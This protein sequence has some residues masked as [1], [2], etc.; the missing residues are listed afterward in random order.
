MPAGNLNA[1]GQT[2]IDPRAQLLLGRAQRQEPIETGMSLIGRLAALGVGQSQQRGF[3]EQIAASRL[4]YSQALQQAGTDPTSRLSVLSQAAASPDPVM[5]SDALS[6]IANLT[7]QE[8]KLVSTPGGG[9]AAV[10]LQ[11]NQ[12]SGVQPVVA[13]RAEAPKMFEVQDGEQTRTFMFDPE[14]GSMVDVATAPRET[15]QRILPPDVYEQQIGLR[16]AAGRAQGE[17]TGAALAGMTD[18]AAARA[19]GADVVAQEK[20]AREQA[21]IKAR[22]TET[23]T[24]FREAVAEWKSDPT[25]AEK[26]SKMGAARQRMTQ[27]LAA[28]R[29][30]PRA[31]TDAD[32]AA[33]A[34]AIPDPVSGLAMLGGMQGGD[35]FDAALRVVEGELG[36]TSTAAPP[37]SGQPNLTPAELRRMADLLEKSRAAK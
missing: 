17:A 2:P 35:P 9:T 6:Q 8:T 7:K 12:V 10:N 18:E 26:A 14:S 11:G 13:G 36:V 21:R 4:G 37:S 20:D 30:F 25:N 16:T 5:R 29:S 1:Y 24:Q 34:Q 15:L 3:E 31:P 23:S 19:R 33:A 22:A 27:E 28:A 32:W